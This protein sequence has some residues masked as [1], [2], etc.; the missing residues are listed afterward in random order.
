MTGRAVRATAV[1]V[2]TVDAAVLLAGL[3]VVINR[4]EPVSATTSPDRGTVVET[5]CID[6]LITETIDDGNPAGWLAYDT[7]VSC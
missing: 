5:R 4:P 3:L 6:E 2:L 7:G 1:G